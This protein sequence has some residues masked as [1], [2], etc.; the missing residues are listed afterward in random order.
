MGDNGSQGQ[1]AMASQTSMA[2]VYSL[3]Y[4]VDLVYCIDSTGSMKNILDIVKD[5]AV[6]F[7]GDFVKKM[8]E[9]NKTIG[10]LRMK[11]IA[12]RDYYYDHEDAMLET[13]FFEMPEQAEE[14]KDCVASIKADGGGD[15]PEDGLEALAFAIKSDWCQEKGKKRHV[16]VVWSDAATHELGFGSTAPNYPENMAK[17][18]DEL[19]SWWGNR[20]SPGEMDESAKRLL[21]FTPNYPWWSR[22]KD[23]WNNSILYE[24]RAGKGLDDVD[25]EQI[26]NAICNS[27]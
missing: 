23:T 17:D 3:K 7:Y 16:I 26:L 24:S 27:V 21:M 5:N 20:Q 13:D 11:I 14:L 2:G 15:D 4:N 6:N 10:R 25:Y 12:F 19:T 18:F 8:N 1:N 9:K 22:I